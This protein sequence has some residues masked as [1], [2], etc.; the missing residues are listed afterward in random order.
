M[1]L[2]TSVQ[3]GPYRDSSWMNHETVLMQWKRLAI[4][5][6]GLSN[7]QIVLVPV[8]ISMVPTRCSMDE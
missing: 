2:F 8:Y 1:E 7:T 6:G 3:L 4:P 5:K